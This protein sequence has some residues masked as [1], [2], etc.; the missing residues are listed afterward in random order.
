MKEHELERGKR[1][2][3]R[4][5]GTSNEAAAPGEPE[6]PEQDPLSLLLAREL[7][8]LDRLSEPQLPDAEWF[9]RMVEKG[10]R[11]SRRK[12]ARDLTLF[13]LSALGIL[14]IYAAVTLGYPVMFLVIQLAAVAAVPFVV[15]AAFKRKRVSGRD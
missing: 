1:K 7:N 13:W 8:K 14:T 15:M 3:A 10:V 11:E 6:L 5:N 4:P 9:E 2:D 12:L